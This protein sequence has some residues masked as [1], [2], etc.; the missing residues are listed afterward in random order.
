MNRVIRGLIGLLFMGAC[1]GGC[2]GK[3]SAAAGNSWGGPFF[4]IVMS[5]PQF[6]MFS[7]NKD[8]AKETELMERAMA[9]ANR[10]RPAFVVFCGDLVNK[11]GDAGQIAAFKRAAAKL[12]KG[13]ALHVVAGNHDLG[14]IPTEESIE[15]YRQDFGEDWY[16]FDA[17]G[18][19]FIVLNTTLMHQP[20]KAAEREARQME[21]LREDLRTSAARGPRQTVLFVHHPLFVKKADEQPDYHNV[22]AERREELLKLCG[23]Y[24]IR[25]AFAGHL[26]RCA[27]GKYEGLELFACGPLGKPLG[28][29]PS[30]FCIVK[31][32]GDRIERQYVGLGEVPEAVRMEGK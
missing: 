10:L 25:A 16:S 30:G 13:I 19:H 11:A 8:C 18:S 15:K 28:K 4:F 5:D 23:Q 24:G 14:N 29:D 17:S 31:V 12:D 21:W 7:E 27:E 20:G 1:L 3:R 26:H 32:Y 22:P 6:G 9:H 2:A